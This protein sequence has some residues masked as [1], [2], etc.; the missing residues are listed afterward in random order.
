[1]I[2]KLPSIFLV[3]IPLGNRRVKVQIFS[4]DKTLMFG[5]LQDGCIVQR[6]IIGFLA[7]MTAINA[8]DST[9]KSKIKSDSS[10]NNKH[11]VLH[12]SFYRRKR[13]QSIL[14]RILN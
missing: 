2:C 7:R 6:S 13:I 9:R 10:E 4:R 1:M 11:E 14:C 8:I 3:L 5:P 12:P